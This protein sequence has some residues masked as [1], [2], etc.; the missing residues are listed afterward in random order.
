[1]GEAGAGTRMTQWLTSKDMLQASGTVG[2]GVGVWGNPWNDRDPS[3]PTVLKHPR[4]C[5]ALGTWEPE[6]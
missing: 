1:M 2:D 5:Q 3:V 4:M 6:T